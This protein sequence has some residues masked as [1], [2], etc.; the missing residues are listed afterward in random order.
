MVEV[1]RKSKD[2]ARSKRISRLLERLSQGTVIVEGAHDL[3]ALR[4]LGID[5]LTYSKLHSS[6]PGAKRPVYILTDDDRGGEEKKRKIVA[7]LLE[8]DG[9][10]AIDDSLGLRLLRMTNSTSVE[11]VRGP[12]EEA[13][14]RMNW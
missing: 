7:M 3:R 4:P 6:L 11:Q 2:Y 5:A 10:Y 9:G 8:S 14:E 13:M 12:I 1:Q